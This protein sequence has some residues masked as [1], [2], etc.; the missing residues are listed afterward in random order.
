MA[1]ALPPEGRMV[2]CDLSE[3]WTGIA[4]RYWREAG[5][6]ERIDL[7]LGPATGT[8]AELIKDGLEST[9]DF[10]FIDADKEAYIDYYELGLRL[11]RVGGVIAVDN[12]LWY[13]RVAD[14]E[15]QEPD[16]AAI[17]AFNRLLA[18]DGRVELSLVPIGDGMTLCR[19]R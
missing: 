12:T 15:D 9:F 19:R 2:C 18:A 16:T 5:V 4:R 3:A 17:R 11:V 13:G 8:L 1:L 10:M 14:P 7:R 6:E